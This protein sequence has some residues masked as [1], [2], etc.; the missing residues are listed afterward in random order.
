METYSIYMK[1]THIATVTG[2]ECA[3]ELYQKF[4][5]C[6]ED[7]GY[8]VSLVWDDTAEVIAYYDPEESD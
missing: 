2:T 1:G 7:L 5:S 8:S 4:K 3:Y 6:G